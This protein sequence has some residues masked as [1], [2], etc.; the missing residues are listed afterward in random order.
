MFQKYSQKGCI[1]ECSLNFAIE[2]AGCLPWD[3]PVPM[4]RNGTDIAV[5]HSNT[6]KD[7]EKNKLFQ[8]Y[9]AMKNQTNLKKCDCLPDCEA[10]K[11]E[12]QES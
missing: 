4:K 11:F 9:E 8:F 6:L 10:T 3:F 7:P 2:T 12:T 5:C 1:F